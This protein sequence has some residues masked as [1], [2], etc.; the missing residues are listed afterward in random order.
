LIFQADSCH[1]AIAIFADMPMLDS[2]ATVCWFSPGFSLYFTPADYAAADAFAAQFR[3]ACCRFYFASCFREP[4][5]PRF[6]SRRRRFAMTLL[7]PP[8]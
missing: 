3:Y 7:L 1:A 5:T 4:F 6:A 8:A 2:H